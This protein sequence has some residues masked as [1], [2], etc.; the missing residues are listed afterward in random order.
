M[1][2][3]EIEQ[4]LAAFPLPASQQTSGSNTNVSFFRSTL[5]C[6]ICHGI[7]QRA[8][9][10]RRCKHVFCSNCI[11]RWLVDNDCC[12]VCREKA[13]TEELID[14][15]LVDIIVGAYNGIKSELLKID[16]DKDTTRQD[17]TSDQ[18]VALQSPPPPPAKEEDEE[19]EV[20][21]QRKNEFIDCPICGE[22]FDKSIISVHVN[23]CITKQER[24]RTKPKQS[25]GKKL[26]LDAFFN[27]HAKVEIEQ[28]PKE[29][30]KPKYLVFPYFKSVK[31]TVDYLSTMGFDRNNLIGVSEQFVRKA[32]RVFKGYYDSY[33]DLHGKVP[34]SR[35]KRKIANQI[36]IEV[37]IVPNQ[38]KSM[39][40]PP[41]SPTKQE[42]GKVMRLP[43]GWEAF[44]Y[45]DEPY[46][47][48][49]SE[50]MQK[51]QLFPPK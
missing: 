47:F 15:P 30:V 10:L 17:D 2:A 20:V 41:T 11:R 36:L 26:T 25:G 28:E 49:W 43:E 9:M 12:A 27:P 44:K 8:F 45:N 5:E 29:K 7:I 33:I 34:N 46:V 35:N 42:Q 1:N 19:D 50:Q 38:S 23:K 4:A 3:S 14:V 48:Y 51:L 22:L 16:V 6:P 18:L 13:F 32:V 37:G 40:S 24:K 31:E 39:R 21:I